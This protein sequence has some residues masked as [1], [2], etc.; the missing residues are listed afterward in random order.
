MSC[1]CMKVCVE[2]KR[3]QLPTAL[4]DPRRR[5]NDKNW[6]IAEKLLE[7]SIPLVLL[8]YSELARVYIMEFHSLT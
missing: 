7:L 3:A 4:L 5:N 2:M 8:Y 6:F 1:W